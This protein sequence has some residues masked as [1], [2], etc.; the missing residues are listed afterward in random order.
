M[1]L[2]AGTTV[3]PGVPGEARGLP[4]RLD[5]DGIAWLAL[6]HQGESVVTLTLE[7]M[8]ALADTLREIGAD[9]RVRAL[10]VRGPG[11][12]MFCAGA[13]IKLV[14][15]VASAAEGEAAAVA[16]RTTFARLR[17][18]AVP[19]VAAIEGPCLGGGLEL[20]L[21]C[22]V[23]LASDA[24]STRIGLPEV[25]LG[26]LPGFGGTVNL[27]RL[28]GLPR[29]LDV[30]LQGKVLR[31]LQALK[32]GIVDRVVPAERLEPLARSTALALVQAGRKSPARRLPLAARLLA[33]APARW[34]LARSIRNKLRRGPARLYPAPRRALEVCLL[35]AHAPLQRAFAEEARALGELVVTP[36]SKGLV[37]VYFLTEASRRLGKQPGTDVARAMVVGGG[38][39]GAGIAGLFA[40]HGIRTRLCDLDTA[41]LVR[42]RRTLQADVDGRVRKKSLDR[43]AAREVMDRLAV[44]T[45]W[46]SLRETQ[47]WLEAV[48]EDVHVKQRL[49]TAAVER[50]LPRDAV[51]ATNTSSLSVDEV[52]EGIP[53]PERV[54]GIH[55][56]NPPAK[57]PLVEVV[58]GKRTSDAAVHAAC[59]LAVRLGKYPVVVRDAPGFLVNRC[60]APYL[61]EAATLLLEGNEPSFLDRT[62]LD[63]GMPMGPCRLL[64]EIGFDVAAKVSE[65]LCAA[66]PGR[67]VASPLFAAMVEARALG[68][69]SGGGILG[70][71]GKG[72]GPGMDVVRRLRAAIPG[73]RPQATRTEVL[74]RL[75]HPLVDEACRCL[76][77]G[78]AASEQDVDLAMVTGIGFPPFHGGLFGYARR[79]GL[80]RIVASLDELARDV[81]PRFSPS[82]AL[83]RRAVPASGR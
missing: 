2:V 30:V 20:A 33:M 11:P 71:D 61:N 40:S 23:R 38:V 67:M 62:L 76:D 45:E 60:L 17:E 58:R 66:H 5:T 64:D 79:E 59:R 53:C 28:A 72:A 70:A 7:R 21:F 81:H 36:E 43:A 78:V 49:M 37:Q 4:W 15:G 22:D 69:K 47:L 34:L 29:A 50:G 14:Q 82:D 63:F 57:M 65:V 31:P 54:V 52:S 44:S 32:A 80:Q 24:A 41:A 12:A 25:K 3:R 35:A 9:T 48:V 13:D 27:V 18:L 42:A 39:M 75:V 46:G 10:V 68:R 56:F 6:G 55:F 83:R 19:V 26:I 73:G 8:E 74:R 16:G 51:L 1:T 77:E